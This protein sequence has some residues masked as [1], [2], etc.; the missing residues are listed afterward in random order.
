MA[1]AVDRKQRQARLDQRGW[2]RQ[3]FFQIIEAGDIARSS[4]Y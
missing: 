2:Q 1:L 3:H 4:G